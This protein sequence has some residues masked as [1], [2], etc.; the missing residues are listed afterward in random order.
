MILYQNL[1]IHIV[2]IVWQIVKGVTDEILAVYKSSGL[3]S[4]GYLLPNICILR[5]K[6]HDLLDSVIRMGAS[7]PLV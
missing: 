7:D 2:I 5:F 4:L 6:F 1:Q 3:K